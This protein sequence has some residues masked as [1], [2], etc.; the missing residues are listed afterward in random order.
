[1]SNLAQLILQAPAP[2]PPPSSLAP[3][4]TT[5]AS[6]RSLPPGGPSAAQLHQAEAWATQARG[7]IEKARGAPAGQKVDGKRRVEGCELALAVTLFNLAML[8]EVRS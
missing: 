2:S 5:T 4:D 6:T 3:K 7:V 8:R 1:M